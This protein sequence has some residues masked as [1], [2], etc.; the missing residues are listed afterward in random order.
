MLLIT[1]TTPSFSNVQEK[2]IGLHR[3]V[4]ETELA[5]V[6]GA[7]LKGQAKRLS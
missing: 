3:S 6:L 5:A 7:G 4:S 2:E 1:I